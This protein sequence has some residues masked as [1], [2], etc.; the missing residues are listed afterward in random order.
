MIQKDEES[1]KV[2]V[3]NMQDLEMEKLKE[4]DKYR[5]EGILDERE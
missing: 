3:Y 4:Q 1:S 5:K 2:T